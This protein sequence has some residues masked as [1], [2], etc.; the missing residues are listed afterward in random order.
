M[1]SKQNT[2]AQT[3]LLGAWDKRLAALAKLARKP[4]LARITITGRKEDGSIIFKAAPGWEIGRTHGGTFIPGPGRIFSYRLHADGR[5]CGH[6]YK[7]C[8][9]GHGSEETTAAQAAWTAGGKTA[10]S[11][12]LK[13]AQRDARGLKLKAKPQEKKRTPAAKAQTQ[14]RKQTRSLKQNTTTAAAA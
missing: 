13:P 12:K 6:G 10:Y 5:I 1:G 8:G 4:A 7:D 11:A 3:R 2:A 9:C 14:Q